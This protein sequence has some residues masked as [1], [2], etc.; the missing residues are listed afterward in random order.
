MS[1]K[2]VFTPEEAE[3]LKA[4]TAKF[5]QSERD[6]GRCNNYDCAYCGINALYNVPSE[7][8]AGE[9][10]PTE[11]EY[12]VCIAVKGRAL[13]SV[14]AN[15]FDEAKKKACNEVCD[16]DFGPLEDIE[17]HAVYAE[18]KNDERVDFD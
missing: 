2:P 18:N 9:T 8:T 15:G 11:Q 5:C 6:K 10:S 4:L 7:H 12:I 16:F 13:V 17:W 3:Q 1:N 14:K